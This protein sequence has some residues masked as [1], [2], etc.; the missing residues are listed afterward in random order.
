MASDERV[1]SD[2]EFALILRS[3]AELA[4]RAEQPRKSANGLTLTEMKSA[5]AQAGLDPA[6]V[7]R[8]ARQFVSRATASPL[9][10]LI[11]GPLRHEHDARIHKR[12]D[13]DSAARLL[14]VVRINATDFR[15]SN[16]TGHAS[17]LGMTWDA[18]GGG[19]VLSVVARP[20]ADGTAISV[21]I[22]RQG[23]FVLI[24]VVSFLAVFATVLVGMALNHASPLLGVGATIAGVSGTLS[25]ARAFWASS[26]RRARQR[27]GV[28]MDAIGQTLVQPEDQVS[29]FRHVGEGTTNPA[30]D[31]NE[32]DDV[33]S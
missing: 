11:G 12:I 6:H 3:A 24:G 21:V 31:E 10:R 7:E 1:Y 20:D 28:L 8:A 25:T 27:M 9:E 30:R 26:T 18:P 2:E 19:D 15:S 14:S 22:D 13:E 33:V 23:T 16:A 29:D 17:S 5:A 32:A 4:N